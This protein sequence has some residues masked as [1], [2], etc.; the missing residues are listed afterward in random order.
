[1]DMIDLMPPGLYEAVITEVDAG[2][3]HP[4]LIQGKYLFRLEARTLDNIRAF[5]NNDEAD[6]RRFATMARLSEVNLAL[7][8]SFAQPFVQAMATEKSAET[9]REMH[10]SRLRFAAFSDRNPLMKGV[11]AMAEQARTDRKPVPSDNP[12]LAMEQATSTWISTWLEALRISRDG[13][14]EAFFVTCYGAPLLQALTGM[15]N[16]AAS[17]HVERD[18]AREA[19]VARLRA[20]LEKLFEAGGMPEA[21]MRALLYV[22]M[23]SGSADER[24]LATL[25]ALR[26]MRPVNE[27]L[28]LAEVK[29]IIRVQSLLL[30]LDE[31]R[32]VQAIPRLLPASPEERRFA[33]EVLRKVVGASAPPSEEEARRLQRIETLFAAG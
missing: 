4:E 18:L 24:G 19:I 3:V 27:R 25:K 28:H 8:R 16:G 2:T 29:E 33:L 15:A 9:M 21:A 23:A 13:M 30:R 26:E 5:G 12:F 31:E 7:Y 14:T 11:A 22:R 10:P 1:M 32:A 17:H 6:D 20:E